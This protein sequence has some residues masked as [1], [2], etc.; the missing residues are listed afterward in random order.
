MKIF[1]VN[2]PRSPH[3]SILEY[4]PEEARQFIHKKLIGPPLGLLTVASAVSD[5]D[6]TFLEMKAEYDLNRNAISH[7]IMMSDHVRRIDPDI[8]A[9]TFIASEFDLGM[10]LFEAAKKINPEIITVAG[11]LHTTLCP[12]D[13]F[14]D[15]VDVICPGQSAHTF[16]KVAV[17]FKDGTSL[18]KIPGIYI[19][20]DDG[21]HFT[22]KI[23]A[24]VDGAGKDFI[25]PDRSFIN[26]WI[27]TYKVGKS[28]DPAT[29]LFT[30]L[31]CP[32]KC[33][34]CSIWPQYDG[35]YFQ[36]SV[37][38]VI[39]ELK[40]LDDYP[41]VRFSDANTVV[42]ELFVEK[43]F[44]RIKAEG[45]RKF[46][47]MDFRVDTAARNPRIIEKLAKGGLKVVICGFESFRNEELKKYNKSINEQQIKEAINILHQ[48]GIMIRGN[49]VVPPDYSNG[50][51]RALAD[52]AGSY[53][54][55][56]AG[57]TILS[58]MPGTEYYASVKDRIID[59]DLAKY[60]FF[61]SV[62]KTTLPYE[63]FHRNVGKLWMIKKGKD[64]I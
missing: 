61:N 47:I 6:V 58:P 20:S 49:Y 29:Y 10:D 4:A 54:V 12:E 50:D 21:F 55:A 57:Y 59:H 24:Q 63:E 39:D 35:R 23:P 2:P 11:G 37:D 13:F 32:Y 5:F 41:V 25:L 42:D 3:N 15:C 48:N 53:R 60:N 64:V 30:S 34:F 7:E 16:R 26:K 17:A 51:F 1:L 18:E 19:R 62:M 43:L 22:G 46:F 8:V 28:P 45:I 38:S 36:R 56:F 14:K 9:S 44:D 40:L 27:D 31:G 33:T 52:Y